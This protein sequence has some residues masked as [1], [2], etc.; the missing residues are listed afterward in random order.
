MVT[1]FLRG[2]LGNQMFQYAF[3]LHLAKKNDVGLTLD[4]VH[5]NDR[6]P[7][8]NFTYR[9][10]DLP[11]VFAIEP[12]LTPLSRA[13]TAAPIPGVWLGFDLISMNLRQAFG[14]AKIIYENETTGFNPEALDGGGDAILFGRWESEKYFSDI[15]LDVRAAFSFRHP[16]AG[17]AAE[18][19]KTIRATN[20]VSIHV[21]RGD[22]ATKQAVKNLMGSTDLAYYHRAA[23]HVADVVGNPTF[24]IFSDDVEWCEN[25]LKLPY[26]VIFVDPILAGPKAAY[27]LE[28][29]SLTQHN[30]IANST[31]SWWGAWLNKNPGK[32]VVAP[33]RWY[34][35][36]VT[37]VRARDI[38]PERWVTI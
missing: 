38:I 22:Y 17:A 7:R 12:H 10:F 4:T 36:D 2:G 31:F 11:D 32:I 14:R 1:V 33:R 29:M 20:S 23:E 8:K 37:N 5:L 34:A 27:H 18:I 30:I 19:V 15:A 24:F 35:D 3:G 25:H 21:R 6:F 16:L 13:A 28:L 26:K 9:T